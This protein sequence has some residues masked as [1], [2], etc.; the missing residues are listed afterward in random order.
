MK[1]ILTSILGFFAL[2]TICNSQTFSLTPLGWDYGYVET[3]S[4]EPSLTF[5]ATNYTGTGLV[6]L[7]LRYL[8]L[9]TQTSY[10]AMT[11]LTNSGPVGPGNSVTF[12]GGIKPDVPYYFAFYNTSVLPQSVSIM[13]NV[14]IITIIGGVP[15]PS[16]I[17]LIILCVIC[18]GLFFWCCKKKA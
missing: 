15:E 8:E 7:Y 11:G 14:G 10:D 2:V 6:D 18:A 17:S 4:I 12:P 5:Y 9:P 1:K 16:A 13:N 3:T